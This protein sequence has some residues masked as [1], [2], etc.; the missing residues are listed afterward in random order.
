MPDLRESHEGKQRLQHRHHDLV[1]PLDN[2]QANLREGVE[3]RGDVGGQF[4]PVLLSDIAHH[5][6]DKRID[7][8]APKDPSRVPGDPIDYSASPHRS[9]VR[10][11]LLCHGNFP[12][13]V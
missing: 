5:N 13:K 12:P 11:R 9:G 3:P 2:L 4:R 8:E 10:V 1:D 6:A 7:E